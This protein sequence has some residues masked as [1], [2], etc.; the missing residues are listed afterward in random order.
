M[1]PSS[2]LPLSLSSFLSFSFHSSHFIA[3][4]LYFLYTFPSPLPPL[5]PPL[6]PLSLPLFPSDDQYEV[7]SDLPE[8]AVVFYCHQCRER[9]ERGRRVEGERERRV[10]GERPDLTWREAV[11]NCMREAFTKV[12]RGRE[13][14]R[15]GERLVAWNTHLGIGEWAS[16]NIALD[17]AGRPIFRA[18]YENCLSPPLS[19]LHQVLEVLQP[20]V[21]SS[22]F[23]DLNAL[24]REVEDRQW[25]SVVGP[26]PFLS[27]SPPPPSL[28]PFLSLPPSPLSLSLPLSSQWNPSIRDP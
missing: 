14:R 6:P 16:P 27:L 18:G 25:S 3:T 15:E 20:P 5:S 1:R 11:N 7:L 10:E 4:S 21:H 28:S 22:L 24:R 2:F 23:S 8:E 19:L 9:R 26:A 13:G 12:G 17:I